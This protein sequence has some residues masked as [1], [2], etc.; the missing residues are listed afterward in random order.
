MENVLEMGGIGA[1]GR[2]K[3]KVMEGIERR[4]KSDEWWS[5]ERTGLT[6]YGTTESKQ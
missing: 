5:D 4:T 2:K 1:W 3:V 6:R